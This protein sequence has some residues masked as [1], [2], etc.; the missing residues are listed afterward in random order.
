M[1]WYGSHAYLNEYIRKHNCV[2]ILE[3]GVYTGENAVSNALHRSLA[4]PV[5]RGKAARCKETES[6][7]H[8]ST[9]LSSGGG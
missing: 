6:W 9:W 1:P 7:T 3:I 4:S 8:Q 2:R 5:Q